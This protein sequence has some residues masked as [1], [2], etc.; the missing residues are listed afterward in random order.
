M[1]L[2]TFY[3]SRLRRFTI[4]NKYYYIYYNHHNKCILTNHYYFILEKINREQLFSFRKQWQPRLKL[5][6]VFKDL[7]SKSL[8]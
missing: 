1:N 6:P 3:K 5:I 4:Y 7:H 8:N 2:K